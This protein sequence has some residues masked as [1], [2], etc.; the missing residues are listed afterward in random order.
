MERCLFDIFCSFLH[1][2]YFVIFV[3]VPFSFD[4]GFPSGILGSDGKQNTV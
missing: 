4:D 1:V 2:N 3:L